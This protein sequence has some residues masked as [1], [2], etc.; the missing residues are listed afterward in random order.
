MN[1][2]LKSEGNYI[3]G[4]PDGKFLIYY[5]TGKLKEE[6][7]YVNGFKEKTWRK[8]DELGVISLTVAYENDIE[9]RINGIKIEDIKRN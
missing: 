6:Q 7:F 9:K 5:D 3:Q 4:N 1:G 2:V 8:F